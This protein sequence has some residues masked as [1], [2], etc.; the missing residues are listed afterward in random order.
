MKKYKLNK[1]NEIPLTDAKFEKLKKIIALKD[2]DVEPENFKHKLVELN[3]VSKLYDDLIKKYKKDYEIES[4]NDKT[5]AWKQKYAPRNVKPIDYQTDKLKTE[6]LSN[7]GKSGINQPMQLNLNEIS[8]P[9]W[10]KITKNDF[11]SLIK[12]G[13][14]NLDDKGYK[15]RA[16]N[17]DYDLKNAEKYLL[18]III[19][20]IS[21]NEA[22]KLYDSLIKPDVDT[23]KNSGV[24]IREII[25]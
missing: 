6:S 5:D 4:R 2:V 7:E 11:I 14:N 13:A 18:E 17:V 16:N 23:L 3:K 25:F 20:K 9:L 1:F 22:H 8:E 24:E 10:I 21:K 19:K 12:D 15:S